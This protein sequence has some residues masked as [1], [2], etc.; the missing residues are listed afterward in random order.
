[1]S[2]QQCKGAMCINGCLDAI[3]VDN[4]REIAGTAALLAAN[5]QL[6]EPQLDALIGLYTEFESEVKRRKRA[7]REL[8]E[9]TKTIILG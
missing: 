4:A 1:M 6:S 9:A 2:E 7:D 8:R 5:N 3:I